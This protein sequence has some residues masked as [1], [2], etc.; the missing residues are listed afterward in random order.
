M[1]SIDEYNSLPIYSDPVKVIEIIYSPAFNKSALA[2]KPPEHALKK[3]YEASNKILSTTGWTEVTKLEVIRNN[4]G[5]FERK[6]EFSRDVTAEIR[7]L[8]AYR[9]V[10]TPLMRPEIASYLL[11]LF[12]PKTTDLHCDRY[13]N[14]IMPA[15]EDSDPTEVLCD[16]GTMATAERQCITIV[17]A[18][19]PHQTPEGWSRP[20]FTASLPK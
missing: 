8:E 9:D 1:S 3:I 6:N 13:I 16:D 12:R 15:E 4:K 10:T 17:G 14:M 11:S 5:Q 2:F 7:L 18:D 20:I 19:C